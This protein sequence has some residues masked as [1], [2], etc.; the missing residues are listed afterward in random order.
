MRDF[1]TPRLASFDYDEMEYAYNQDD[2]EITEEDRHLW[3]EQQRQ[4]DRDWYTIEESSG[5]SFNMC[6]IRFLLRIFSKILI[7]INF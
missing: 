4:L 2:G 5:V 7:L 3:E 6:Y 1:P